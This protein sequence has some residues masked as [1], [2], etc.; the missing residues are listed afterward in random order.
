MELIKLI[1]VKLDF[2]QRMQA[3]IIF[4]CVAVPL[5]T[6]VVYSQESADGRKCLS[7]FS[8]PTVHGSD[9]V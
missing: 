6:N 1:E 9:N 3:S 7:K 4:W 2:H 8:L 5:K